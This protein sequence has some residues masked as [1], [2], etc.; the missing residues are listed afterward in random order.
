MDAQLPF[1]DLRIIE[2][3]GVL[4][5][6]AVGMFFAELGATVIKIENKTTGGD[7]IPFSN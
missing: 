5:G 6:P 4:A 3:A 2:L 7:I 1:K